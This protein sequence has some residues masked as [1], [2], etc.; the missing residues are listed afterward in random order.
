MAAIEY[1]LA[2]VINNRLVEFELLMELKLE[3]K[4]GTSLHT[5]CYKDAS[6]SVRRQCV[7]LSQLYIWIFDHTMSETSPHPRKKISRIWLVPADCDFF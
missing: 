1:K 5:P 6:P 2:M 4:T 7:C 3:Q